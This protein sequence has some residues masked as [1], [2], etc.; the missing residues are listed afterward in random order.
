MKHARLATQL[1]GH[2]IR[3][4]LKTILK[5]VPFPVRHYHSKART[6]IR[7]AWMGG[8]VVTIKALTM[9]LTTPLIS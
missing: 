6:G 2:S 7:K 3:G 5:L 1:N 4:F 9:A 8:K